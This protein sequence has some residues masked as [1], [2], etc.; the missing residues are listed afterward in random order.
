MK[1]FQ[2]NIVIIISNFKKSHF[3][4]LFNKNEPLH[5]KLT[6]YIQRCASGE[7]GNGLDEQQVIEKI[8]EG[9]M[10]AFD[11]LYDAYNKKALR[12]A[13][14]MTG[15]QNMA[16]DIVQEVFI[17]CYL[18]I[19]KLKHAEYF[20]TW[21]YKILKRT[22]W[23]HIKKE[24]KFVLTE[25]TEELENIKMVWDDPYEQSDLSTFLISQIK[26]MDYKKQTTVILYYYN[27]LSVKEIAKVMG[28]LEGTVKSRLNSARKQL[29]EYLVKENYI[30]RGERVLSS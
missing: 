3:I 20:K 1:Y 22:A 27:E 12:M 30:N 19:D 21:F 26:R 8:R 14:L 25:T 16:K 11:D 4:N 7:G 9:D 13:Y 28:C 6:L 10:A 24:N 2:K 5:V 29:K 23:R 17:E 18:S 15:N